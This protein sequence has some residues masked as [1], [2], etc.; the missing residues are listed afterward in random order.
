[1]RLT[2]RGNA[3]GGR[4]KAL[5]YKSLTEVCMV[6]CYKATSGDIRLSSPSTRC[7]RC[8]A[9]IGKLSAE[10]ELTICLAPVAVSLKASQHTT[11]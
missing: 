6:S 11:Q 7:S 2:R 5:P 10:V 1:M 9:V 8:S 3:T 4:R